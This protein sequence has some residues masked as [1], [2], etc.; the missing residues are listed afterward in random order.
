MHW[1]G[2]GFSLSHQFKLRSKYSAIDTSIKVYWQCLTYKYFQQYSQPSAGHVS[3]HFWSIN[4]STKSNSV[5]AMSGGYFGHKV[6]ASQLPIG[7]PVQIWDENIH[8]RNPAFPFFYHHNISV[9]PFLYLFKVL[10][11]QLL[12]NDFCSKILT[13]TVCND[14]SYS[15]TA[16]LDNLVSTRLYTVNTIS[17]WL[18]CKDQYRTVILPILTGKHDD[19]KYGR[20]TTHSRWLCHVDTSLS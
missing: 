1:H 6:S 2:N 9:K 18:S 19:Y 14:S 12:W 3:D 15:C 11:I 4:T 7:S 8:R 13:A 20:F 5:L 10:I 17:W 16:H